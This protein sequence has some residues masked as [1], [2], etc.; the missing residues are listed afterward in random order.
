MVHEALS[1]EKEPI[2]I[3]FDDTREHLEILIPGRP[4]EKFGKAVLPAA[5]MAVFKKEIAD[6]RL[7]GVYKKTGGEMRGSTAAVYQ[8]ADGDIMYFHLIPPDNMAGYICLGTKGGN[9]FE[10]LILKTDFINQSGKD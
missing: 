5:E 6:F 3:H 9:P 10:K 4:E 2:S 8:N 7:T 1:E